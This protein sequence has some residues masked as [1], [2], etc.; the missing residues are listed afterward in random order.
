MS[1]R[2]RVS[3]LKTKFLTVDNA[4]DKLGL[5]IS[6]YMNTEI[7]CT[8]LNNSERFSEQV[9][10]N[11]EPLVLSTDDKMVLIKKY[12]QTLSEDEK[13]KCILNVDNE[14]CE[15]FSLTIKLMAK[16]NEKFGV[17]RTSEHQ[18]FMKQLDEMYFKIALMEGIS[19]N[20]KCFISTSIK[21]MKR[22]EAEKKVN[23][24]YKFCQMLIDVNHFD[25][26]SC[27]LRLDRMPFGL[28]DY[29]IQF[30]TCTNTRQVL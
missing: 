30:F 9:Q 5:T 21:A 25:H 26:S 17:C 20:P 10:R 1:I 12:M 2:S 27:L 3:F 16:V 23:L 8:H 29:V 11:V 6:H 19:S 22:L 7:S 28:L 24:V 14:R 18:I 4:E 15:L 13:V